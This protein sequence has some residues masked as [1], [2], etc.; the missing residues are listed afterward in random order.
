MIDTT[1]RACSAWR[2]RHLQERCEARQAALARPPHQHLLEHLNQ[3]ATK[4]WLLASE[5]LFRQRNAILLVKQRAIA[6]ALI[7]AAGVR[8]DLTRQRRRSAQVVRIGRS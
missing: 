7:E 8:L 2:R 3:D 4:S 6:A 1:K 5:A